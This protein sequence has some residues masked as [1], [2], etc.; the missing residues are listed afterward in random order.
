MYTSIYECMP[1]LQSGDID[2]LYRFYKE[3][4]LQERLPKRIDLSKIQLSYQIYG[5][6]EDGRMGWGN[7]KENGRVVSEAGH[8]TRISAL[9]VFL[10]SEY[11]LKL[12]YRLYLYEQGWTDYVQAGEVCGT[13]NILQYAQAMEIKLE[14]ADA[15]RVCLTYRAH[16]QN[17]GW[18]D[19][20]FSGEET[21]DTE[22]KLHL[23]SF[24]IQ[25]D[26]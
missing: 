20:K 7:Q 22:G 5:D 1:L 17:Q 13:E 2:G 18:L 24:M 10:E 12:S 14:G 15:D 9:R 6:R 19:I 3:T 16:V 26:E 4:Y 23:E 25:I 11:D 8:G 21:G